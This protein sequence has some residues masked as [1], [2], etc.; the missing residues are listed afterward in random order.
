[1]ALVLIGD[2][3]RWYPVSVESLRIFLERG[4]YTGRGYDRPY[5]LRSNIAYNLQYFEYLDRTTRDLKLSS[6]LHKQTYKTQVIIGC[7]IIESILHYLVVATGKQATSS[8]K[9]EQ[10]FTG[11]N[12]TIEGKVYRVDSVVKLQSDPPVPTPMTFDA[13]IKKAKAHKLLGEDSEL[14]ARL[15]RLRALRNK[16]HLQQIGEPTDHDFN[17]FGE[18]ARRL[19]MQVLHATMVGPVFKP[20]A[21]QEGFFAYMEHYL[22]E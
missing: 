14:Y 7:G 2:S 18:A 3:G 5:A 11:A 10:E 12:K 19:V 9:V 22:A 21:L 13:L 4:I 15:N 17:T 16:I 6:V 20:S 1:M 8:W